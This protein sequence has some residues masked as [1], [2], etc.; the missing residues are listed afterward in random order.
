MVHGFDIPIRKA[1]MF[2][3]ALCRARAMLQSLDIPLIPIATNLREHG[4]DWARSYG[5][6]LASALSLFAGA[7]THGIIASSFTHAGDPKHGSDPETDHLLSSRGF[8]IVHD[9][10]EYSK[11]DKARAIQWWPA[12]L[13]HLRVCWQ[14]RNLGKNCCKCEKCIRTILFFRALGIFP[15]AFARDVK[16][17]QIARMRIPPISVSSGYTDLLHYLRENNM[18]GAWIDALERN[19]QRPR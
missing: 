10:A 14:G 16:D 7:H 5:V 18:Q 12:A 9:G 6:A 8:Q 4:L 1:S 15:S 17:R 13:Q 11:F 2:S 3:Q 19:L